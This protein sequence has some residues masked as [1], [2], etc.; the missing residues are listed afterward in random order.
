MTNFHLLIGL[1]VLSIVVGYVRDWLLKRKLERYG[2]Q[3]EN[4]YAC[5]RHENDRKVYLR[6]RQHQQ[7]LER[8]QNDLR[9]KVHLLIF[10][11]GEFINESWEEFE[12]RCAHFIARDRVKRH[13][14]LR[15]NRRE[16][17]LAEVKGL[18]GFVLPQV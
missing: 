15:D 7:W 14:W 11:E 18:E 16:W 6:A 5:S 17:Y 1:I 3:A 9:V 12:Q 4:I 2:R 13:T 10:Q 8:S